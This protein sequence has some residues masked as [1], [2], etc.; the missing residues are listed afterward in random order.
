MEESQHG[1]YEVEV[2]KERLNDEPKNVWT[3]FSV[4]DKIS[5]R[6]RTPDVRQRFF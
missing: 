3:V 1:D 5:R 2:R 6:S 4:L